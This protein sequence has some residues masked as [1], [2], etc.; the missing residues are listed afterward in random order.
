MTSST[1]LFKAFVG[2]TK[3]L[4]ESGTYKGDG[5]RRAISAGFN[6]IYSCDVNSLFI[7]RA[8]TTW[9]S[10]IHLLNESSET[11]F[12]KFTSHIK[13]PAVFFLDGHGMPEGQIF[14]SDTTSSGSS[15]CP[16]ME[17][18]EAIQRS[19]YCHIILIDD[20]QS[21]GTWEFNYL[22]FQ[23]VNIRILL[24]NPKYKFLLYGNVACWYDPSEITLTLS[25]FKMRIKASVLRI[26]IFLSRK[27]FTKF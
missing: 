2:T 23:E 12:P 14:T 8:L 24:I 16:I 10:R 11:A 9:G 26:R 5:I 25:F 17:E 27:L 18:L 3:I 13:S 19:L 6:E 1:S 20:Y 15:I 22:T 4:V 21:F 7:E